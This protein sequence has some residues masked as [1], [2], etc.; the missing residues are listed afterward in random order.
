MIPYFASTTYYIGPIPMQTWGTF[1]A[2]GFLVGAYI[3]AKRAKHK[4]LDEARIWDLAFWMFVAGFVGARLLDVLVYEP[5]KFLMHPI[6]IINPFIPGFAIEGGLIACALTFFWYCKKHKLD[7]IDY[8]DATV[9]GLPVGEGI[10]RIGCFLIHD[11]PG[12]LSH[13]LL[14]VKYPDGSSRHDLGLYLSIAGWVMA[15]IF[16]ALDR[17]PR[18]RGFWLGMFIALDSFS[19]LW[20]DSYRIADARYFYLTPT[21]W[22]SIPLI[23]VGVAMVVI[24][25]R[26]GKKGFK[27]IHGS[28]P[29]MPM[30]VM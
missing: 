12:T 2:I 18:P 11:H 13:S 21:Q 30:D 19:R 27:D 8:A 3:A 28:M 1:V 9:W 16:L 4:G 6:N 5:G 15:L 14:A 26:A 7:F 29:G 25:Y 17:Q 24:S 23:I 22:I 20:L 10:G